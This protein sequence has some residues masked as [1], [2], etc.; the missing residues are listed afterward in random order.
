MDGWGWGWDLVFST[1]RGRVAEG[2]EAGVGNFNGGW[3][4]WGFHVSGFDVKRLGMKDFGNFDVKKLEF[5]EGEKR[6]ISVR[7]VDGGAGVMKGLVLAGGR[8]R[9]MGREKGGI[10]RRDGRTFVG[11]AVELLKEAGCAEV[12]LSLRKGQEIPPGGEGLEIARDEGDGPLGGMLSGMKTDEGADW[13]VIACDL[14]RLEV[15][16]LQGLLEGEGEIVVYRG[17]GGIEPLCGL[18]RRGAGDRME[19]AGAGGDRRLKDILVAA[20]A[21]VL[22]LPGGE[23]LGNA[24]EQG[25]L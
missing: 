16:T 18:Y 20:G 6:G 12:V 4:G 9:R 11:R 23:E 15:G 3:R 5:D 8:G 10:V 1:R 19:A 25:E 24:N 14:V 2:A 21:T 22:D 7:V 13:L 17:E